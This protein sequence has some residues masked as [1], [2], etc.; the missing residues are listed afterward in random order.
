[1]QR[2]CGVA[3]WAHLGGCVHSALFT[4]RC[5]GGREWGRSRDSSEL[6]GPGG[7]LL[8]SGLSWLSDNPWKVSWGW[9]TEELKGMRRYLGNWG[10]TRWLPH[11]PGLPECVPGIRHGWVGGIQAERT[12]DKRLSERQTG[13]RE[14]GKGTKDCR[15]AWQR[16][17][18][19]P[20]GWGK[21]AGEWRE[22]AL[23][24]FWGLRLGEGGGWFRVSRRKAEEG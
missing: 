21:K 8:E 11:L 18:P 12:R 17:A 14:P 22:G 1:M 3:R 5:C 7:M 10:Q 4:L 16:P 20:G 6:V 23:P 19:A 13:V 24:G 2:C 9:A 15:V